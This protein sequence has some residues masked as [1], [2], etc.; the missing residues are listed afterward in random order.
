MKMV[1]IL[2]PSQMIRLKFVLDYSNIVFSREQ[3]FGESRR[4][5]AHVLLIF[6]FAVEIY[7]D[8]NSNANN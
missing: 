7:I 1:L 5:M 8:G 6:I 3:I 4:D 2:L